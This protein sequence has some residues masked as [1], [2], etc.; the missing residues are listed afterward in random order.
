MAFVAI[1]KTSSFM[2]CGGE[3]D[4]KAERTETVMQNTKTGEYFVRCA[5]IGYDDSWVSDETIYRAAKKFD[6]LEEANTYVA[7]CIT[8]ERWARHDDT[9]THFPNV[10]Y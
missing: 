2:V 4:M 9:L 5:H 7:S 3:L 1:V 6:T 10:S 8:G